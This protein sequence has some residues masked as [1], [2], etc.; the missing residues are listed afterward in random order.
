MSFEFNKLP[1]AENSILSAVE[2]YE[3]NRGEEGHFEN[4]TVQCYELL[5]RL[6]E[7]Q[8]K[9]QEMEKISFYCAE[10]IE[11]F[12][13]LANIERVMRIY[14]IPYFLGVKRK[15]AEKMA[16]LFEQIPLQPNNSSHSLAYTY[17]RRF[18]D[19]NKLMPT[20]TEIFDNFDE[21]YEEA[22]SSAILTRW[23]RFD[24]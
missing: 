21:L 13:D 7:A 24:G 14:L 17:I 4:E 3:M 9:Q 2:I 16:E 11:D 5:M 10:N 8:G 19:T 23:K 22:V 1:E 12:K 18:I 6:Y 15:Q 20:V